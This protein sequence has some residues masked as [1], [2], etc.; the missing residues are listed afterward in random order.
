MPEFDAEPTRT[1]DAASGL[2]AEL[3]AAGYEDATEIGRGGFGVVYKCKQ[4]ALGRT[5]AIKLLSSDLDQV[6]RERFLREG[7]AMGR[8]SGHP[9]IVNILHVGVT[10]SGRPYIVMPYLPRDSLATQLAREGSPGWPTAVRIGVKLSGALQAAHNSGTLHRDIK[11][12]NVLVDDYGDPQLTDFG[13]ARIDGGFETAS[14]HF[15]GSIA[16]T[17]PEVLDGSPPSVA[18]DIYG[19]GATL[20]ALIG[21]QAA[22]ARRSGEE[23]IAQIVRI[24]STP[25]PDLRQSGVPGDV[26]AVIERAMST[27]PALRQ[28]SA[29]EFGNQLR[30]VQHRLGMTVDDMALPPAPVTEGKPAGAGVYAKAA[31]P[32]PPTMAYSGGQQYVSGPNPTANQATMARSTAD[33]NGR[34]RGPI[35]A[36][37]V[38]ALVLVVG[39]GLFLL[40]DSFTSSDSNVVARSASAGTAET[41]ASETTVV[42]G[43]LV[44]DVGK[45]GWW[46][47]FAITADR[48]TLT[49]DGLLTVDLTYQNLTD[50]N[51]TPSSSGYLEVDG[52]V[53]SA[54]FDF[55]TVPGE[56]TASGKLEATLSEGGDPEKLLDSAMLVYG[57][58]SDNQTKIP[59]NASGDVASTEPKTLDVSGQL[60]QDQIVIDVISGTFTPSYQSGEKDKML[61]ALKVKI[62]CGP[63]CSKYGYNT[64][65]NEFSIKTPDG[66]SV[67]ADSR[68]PYCCDALY[69][70]GVSD[71]ADNIVV[72][73]VP[74]PGTGKY[75]LTYDNLKLTEAGSRPATMTFTV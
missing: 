10:P 9:N 65:V 71:N 5:V 55:P 12:A 52:A 48:A 18:A 45:T 4:P 63:E 67:V 27:D 40:R 43:S 72:F 17:A 53:V 73:V 56:G 66:N 39:G 19:L 21:G 14:G 59:L 38:I 22:Y 61:L 31:A 30:Q 1:T 29:A 50:Q 60:V 2:R 51:A 47:G 13:I 16:Y 74:A 35:I 15:T 23:L 7:F 34:R 11:P 25:V 33:R 68:S 49:P 54:S 46:D 44:R 24:T 64:N 62:S 57:E 28:Q 75:T 41:A 26:C 42:A 6:N 69:P 70:Q 8:L 58:A 36:A 3:A 20:F 37:A 32:P